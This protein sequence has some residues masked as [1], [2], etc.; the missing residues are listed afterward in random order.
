MT[1][2]IHRGT[3]EIGGSCIEL[4]TAHFRLFLDFGL[5]LA[6]NEGKG[7]N[8]RF[9]PSAPISELVADGI[10]PRIPYLIEKK[11]NQP[12]ALLL[13]HSHLD[14]YGLIPLLPNDLPI[15]TSRG[16]KSL[17]V[18]A[19][20]FG[21]SQVDQ[22]Q[23]FSLE[24]WKKFEV[25]GISITPYL[26]DHSAVDAFSYLIEA[27]GTRIF[28]T[29]DI[30]AHGRK[31]ILFKNLITNPPKDVDYLIIE[32]SMIGRAQSEFKTEQ[33]IENKLVEELSSKGLYLASFSSQNIDRFVSFFRACR[34]T[35]RTLVVD[36]Y[37]AA[38]L[39]SIRELS[40]NIPQHDWKTGFKVFFV[41]NNATK[42]M[43][44]DK[45]LFKF[46]S[47]KITLDEIMA[48]KERLVIKENWMIR[49]ILLHK[50]LLDSAKLIYSMWDGYLDRDSFWQQR[51]VP[52]IQIHCSGHAYKDDLKAIIEAINPK[53]VIPNHTFF[54]EAMKDFYSGKTIVLQ[55]GEQFFCKKHD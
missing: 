39:H 30:R 13:T 51:G 18:M 16:T 53:A 36:P 1:I 50:N 7:T 31:Y 44:D 21:Q 11:D 55:D 49:Q 2:T 40:P 48:N 32:G 24:P 5:P 19:N 10:V 54:P 38:I 26:A 35:D 22:A 43:A 6:I 25:N 12:T 37:T 28:Y 14:H 33:D 29:G 20:F 34:K 27:E 3:H 41:P 8:P 45:C 47:A 23:I 4:E 52:M 42:K 46:K 9:D 17:L 15:Y